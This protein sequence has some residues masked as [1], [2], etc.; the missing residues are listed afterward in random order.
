MQP[1]PSRFVQPF[2]PRSEHV[3][4]AAQVDKGGGY[5]GKRGAHMQEG[6]GGV[7]KAVLRRRKGECVCEHRLRRGLPPGLGAKAR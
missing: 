7:R 3:A 1:P 6:G 4:N 5:V 2:T